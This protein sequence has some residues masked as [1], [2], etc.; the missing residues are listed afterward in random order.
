MIREILSEHYRI[1]KRQGIERDI[2]IHDNLEFGDTM[3]SLA[4][5]AAS[6]E[7]LNTKYPIFIQ[8]VSVLKPIDREKPEL[9]LWLSII[10]EWVSEEVSISVLHFTSDKLSRDIPKIIEI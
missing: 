4:Y 9:F 3:Y 10:D 5:K 8:R 2:V 1:V 6:E 7:I